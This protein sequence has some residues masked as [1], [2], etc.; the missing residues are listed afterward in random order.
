M[1]VFQRET[2]CIFVVHLHLP[3]I[4]MLLHFC[5]VN[6]KMILTLTASIMYWYLKQPGEER[7]TGIS[8][9]E[10]SS[11]SETISNSTTDDSSSESSLEEHG[12]L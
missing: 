1:K 6:Q 5:Q 2:S 12:H 10:G 7:P 11:Q 8:D 3:Y 9:S 4:H